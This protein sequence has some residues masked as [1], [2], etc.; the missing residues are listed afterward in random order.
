MIL[1]ESEAIDFREW[2]GPGHHPPAL[3]ALSGRLACQQ[4][5]LQEKGKDSLKSYLLLPGP[6][7]AQ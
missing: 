4:P 5:A 1:V 3:G 7:K 6:L 2:G